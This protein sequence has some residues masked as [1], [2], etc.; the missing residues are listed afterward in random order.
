MENE[1]P[2]TDA[3]LAEIEQAWVRE[4]ERR[5]AE[6]DRGEARLIPGD[7]VFERIRARLADS[8]SAG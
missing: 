2:L 1:E 6:I 3:E 4:A 8:P 5:L 7:E